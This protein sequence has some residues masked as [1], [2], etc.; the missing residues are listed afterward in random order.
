MSS[1][2]PFCWSPM[3]LVAPRLL[4][5]GQDS[6]S[7]LSAS[8][9]FD[10]VQGLCPEEMG[11]PCQKF[12]EFVTAYLSPSFAAEIVSTMLRYKIKLGGGV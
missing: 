4:V 7:D 11:F 8:T 5:S 9:E 12:S 3:V 1:V 10:E 6:I 2:I